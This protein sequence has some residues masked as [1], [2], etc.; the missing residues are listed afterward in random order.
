MKEEYLAT[1]VQ[2][3]IKGDEGAFTK[4]YE[5]Y[6]ESIIYRCRFYLK[7]TNEVDDA[8]QEVVIAMYRNINKLSN[9]QLFNAWLHSIIKNTCNAALRKIFTE[10]SY[11]D[12]KGYENELM[13]ES[14]EFLPQE[15]AEDKEKRKI[16]LSAIDTLP[17]K[18]REVIFMYYYE[19]L[20]YAEISLVLNKPINT[21]STLMA[22]GRKRIK[23]HLQAYNNG[24]YSKANSISPTLLLKTAFEKNIQET[25][26]EGTVKGLI[27]MCANKIGEL[28]TVSVSAPTATLAGITQLSRV[29]MHL[30]KTSSTVS[31][32]FKGA[33]NFAVCT[34]VGVSS[35]VC[36]T[37]SERFS[38][39]IQPIQ[40]PLFYYYD[41]VLETPQQSEISV[42][43][44]EAF[45]NQAKTEEPSLAQQTDTAEGVLSDAFPISD[46][47][48]LPDAQDTTLV[49]DTNIGGN[50]LIEGD[51]ASR[52]LADIKIMLLNSNKE[53]I[54]AT[55][56]NTNGSFSFSI[57]PR[58]Q[59]ENY[60]VKAVVPSNI[61]LCADA[62]TPNASVVIDVTKGGQITDANIYLAYFTQITGNI[63]FSGGNCDCGHINPKQALIKSEINLNWQIISESDDNVLYSGTGNTVSANL[64]DLYNQALNGGYK[65]RFY[66]Q[67]TAGMVGEITRSF[68]IYT[69]EIENGQFS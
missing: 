49:A 52:D 18:F 22:R 30:N 37:N 29:A 41:E 26:S 68:Q 2:N 55:T 31:A 60:T 12:I 47:G 11:I 17:G 50:I 21:V 28:S 19:G 36:V 54:A 48:I 15:F 45:I 64:Q 59:R 34:A 46:E 23:R 13:E 33:I 14:R 44:D 1:V 67:N 35:V 66:Y 3:A 6:M 5:D 56:A 51:K 65:I 27:K 32:M 16:L 10:K 20:S 42:I 7:D 25:I 9:P 57:A 4:L 69:G 62:K 43:E 38:A 53:K 40:I 61:N 63:E 24:S 39:Y 8:V 58:Q